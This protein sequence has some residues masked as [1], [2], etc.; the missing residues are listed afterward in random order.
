MFIWYENLRI[1]NIFLK[2]TMRIVC[3][4]YN[5]ELTNTKHL[6]IVGTNNI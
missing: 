4:F 6:L 1:V 5:K 2:F 3:K